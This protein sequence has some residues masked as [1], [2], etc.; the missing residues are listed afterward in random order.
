MHVRVGHLAVV[1]FAPDI[2]LMS[3]PPGPGGSR[4]SS[5][6]RY[7][8]PERRAPFTEDSF[9]FGSRHAGFTDGFE[10]HIVPDVQAARRDFDQVP[11]KAGIKGW[12]LGHKKREQKDHR[13]SRD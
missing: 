1:G 2:L 10:M 8:S 7:S 12:G 11:E 3:S 6:A 5:S 13:S 4:H 9:D